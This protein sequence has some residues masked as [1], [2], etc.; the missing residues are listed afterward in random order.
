MNPLPL[1]NPRSL[2]ENQVGSYMWGDRGCNLHDVCLTCTLS[3]CQYDEG[4]PYSFDGRIAKR[5]IEIYELREAG[6]T[7][8][9]ISRTFGVSQRTIHR[10]LQDERTRRNE[11]TG[12]ER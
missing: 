10:V 9:H 12:A 7:I 2:P 11:T 4:S 8:E 1:V 6:A 3:M 5:N